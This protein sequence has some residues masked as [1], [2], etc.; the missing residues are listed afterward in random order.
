[1][2]KY[3]L[4]FLAF[5]CQNGDNSGN[6]IE[7]IMIVRVEF[8]LETPL[9]ITCDLFDQDLGPKDTIYIHDKD[10]IWFLKNNIDKSKEIRDVGGIDTRAKMYV[11]YYNHRVDTFCL[12]NGPYFSS[13]N[14]VMEFP[15][16]SVYNWI[17]DLD[18][19]GKY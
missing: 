11:K 12:V 8:S 16:D 1:M 3:L 15:N 17:K 4:L 19:K 9:N 10:N 14:I 7:Q 13:N 2:S 5:V 18:T 6:D